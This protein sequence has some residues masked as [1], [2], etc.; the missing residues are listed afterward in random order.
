MQIAAMIQSFQQFLRQ[1]VFAFDAK[2]NQ[3]F[4]FI[5]NVKRENRN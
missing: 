4:F 2:H 5:E 1:I 3:T